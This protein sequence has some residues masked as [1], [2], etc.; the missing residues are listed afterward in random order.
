MSS[1]DEIIDQQ[2]VQSG[3]CY[4]AALANAPPEL[5][6][7]A[8]APVSNQEGWQHV[9][10]EDHVENIQVSEDRY[11]NIQ[12][13]EAAI[14]AKA[15]T[16]GTAPYGIWLGKQK[17]KLVQRDANFEVNDQRVVCLFANRPRGGAHI[18]ATEKTVVIGLYNEEAGQSSGNC[19]RAVLR[20]VEYLI[21]NG[22]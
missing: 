20:F 11:E 10:S 3:T 21:D 12:I 5:A 14:L 1:W 6:F 2:L 22:C 4:A 17:Y 16:E 9:W 15:I 7:Y 18:V 19:K 8:A 13:S